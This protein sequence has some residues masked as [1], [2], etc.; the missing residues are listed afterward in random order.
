MSRLQ[1]CSH[2]KCL[3]LCWVVT[4]QKRNLM[5]KHCFIFGLCNMYVYFIYELYDVKTKLASSC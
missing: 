5:H 3:K 1:C 2:E 4:L